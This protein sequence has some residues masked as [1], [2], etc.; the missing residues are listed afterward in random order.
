MTA[1]LIAFATSLAWPVSLAALIGVLAGGA[2]PPA[3]GR[4]VLGLAALSLITAG[5]IVSALGLVPGRDGLWLDIG[6]MLAAT[7][8]V[9]CLAAAL[10]RRGLA[11]MVRARRPRA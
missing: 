4:P 1:Q 5:A 8:A 2:L 3:S 11:R 6:V 10:A 7:Y 9:G